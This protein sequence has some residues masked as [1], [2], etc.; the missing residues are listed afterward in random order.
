MPRRPWPPAGHETILMEVVKIK[1]GECPLVIRVK[2]YHPVV[3]IVLV[4]HCLMKAIAD[5]PVVGL[6]SEMEVRRADG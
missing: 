6:P 1:M 2:E 5:Q 4:E 3:K